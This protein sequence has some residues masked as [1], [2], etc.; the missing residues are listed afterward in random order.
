MEV[1]G[2]EWQEVYEESFLGIPYPVGW[3]CR[4]CKNHVN[5]VGPEGLAGTNTGEKVLVGIHGG[6]GNCG[7]GSM[8]REQII[9]PDGTLTIIRP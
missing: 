1:H 7:D 8:Y 4:V 2:C 9:R 6:L 3:R 5:K